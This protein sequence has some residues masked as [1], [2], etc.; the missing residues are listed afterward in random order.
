MEPDGK[1][2]AAYFNP[3]QINV[4]KAVALKDGQALKIFIELRDV[5][6]PGSTYT[7]AYQPENDQLVGIYYQ[8]A[9]QQRFDV[10]FER[11]R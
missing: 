5:N 4:A 3:T 7:L 11:M 10:F 6:Y 9:T 1:M 8:A 2:D